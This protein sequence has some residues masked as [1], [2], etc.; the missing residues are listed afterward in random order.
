MAETLLKSASKSKHIG[1]YK[2]Y[3]YHNKIEFIVHNQ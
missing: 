3:I 1:T 2:K